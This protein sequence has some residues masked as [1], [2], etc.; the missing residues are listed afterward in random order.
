MAS[1]CGIREYLHQGSYT[2]ISGSNTRKYRKFRVGLGD[3]IGLRR[4][5]RLQSSSA[6]TDSC[7]V[8]IETR[9]ATR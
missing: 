7:G 3:E 6:A 9:S 8:G 4:P 5:N 1:Q 2:K